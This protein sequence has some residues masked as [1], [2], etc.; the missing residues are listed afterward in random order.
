MLLFVI[1][2]D[3]SSCSCTEF[4][5]KGNAL[6]W[7][8]KCSVLK[9]GC[10]R[11]DGW[12]GDERWWT[13]ELAD[14]RVTNK[15]CAIRRQSVKP[16]VRGGAVGGVGAVGRKS[17]PPSL[18]APP[19]VRAS[20]RSPQPRPSI[21]DTSPRRQ[22]SSSQLFARGE[23]ASEA[24]P[25]PATCRTPLLVSAY[26]RTTS[27]DSYGPT[28]ITDYDLVTF[29]SVPRFQ[30]DEDHNQVLEEQP[31]TP[32]AYERVHINVSGWV[33]AFTSI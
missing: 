26:T 28:S 10:S 31:D 18:R 27:I 13:G 23:D 22:H 1:G 14:E 24:P 4:I 12:E 7:Y 32:S 2:H 17:R 5:R 25:S 21:D 19:A 6:R 3:S 15:L 9:S 20:S 33:S 16:S 8:G 30:T 11:D 29:R